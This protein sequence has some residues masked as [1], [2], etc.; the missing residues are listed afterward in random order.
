MNSLKIV[1]TI[2]FILT[3]FIFAGL[4]TLSLLISKKLKKN[5]AP[6]ASEIN[7]F[8][9]KN[10]KIKQ[11]SADGKFLYILI[12]N[13]DSG[14]KILLYDNDE[15]KVVSTIRVNWGRV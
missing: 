1:K 2:V 14:D 10:S 5:E 3:F 11:I 15:G 6:L 9:E 8:Q 12:K 4:I 7:L 13:Q